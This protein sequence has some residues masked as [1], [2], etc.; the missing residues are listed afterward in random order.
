[1]PYFGHYGTST[2]LAFVDLAIVNT[3]TKSVLELCEIE[4]EGA[5]PKKVIGD[6][7]NIFISDFVC[8]GRKQYDLNGAHLLL[9]VRVE[10]KGRSSEKITNLR[11][12]IKASV[13]EEFL[14]DIELEFVTVHDYAS[15]VSRLETQICEILGVQQREGV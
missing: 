7:F 10:S 4:E 9:G 5:N 1:V 12:R 13:K 6:C 14:K 8:I 15:L 3:D 11:K 2:T